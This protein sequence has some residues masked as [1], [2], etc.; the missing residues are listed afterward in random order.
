LSSRALPLS[1]SSTVVLLAAPAALLVGVLLAARTSTGL[2]AVV[3]LLYAPL[4]FFNLPLALTL[5]VPLT[6]MTSLHFAWSGPA[7]ISVM[8]LAAWIGTLAATRAQR[9]A[10]LSRQRFIVAAIVLFLLWGTLSVLW[11]TDSTRA[12]EA[13]LDWLVA[14][15]V[16]MIVATTITSPRQARF[17][18][19]AFVIGGVAS[20]IIGFATTGLRPSPS[21]LAGASQAEGRLTGGSGDPNYLAAG[22]VASIVIAAALLVTTRRAAARVGLLFAIAILVAGMVASQSRG[23][24]LASLGASLAALVLFKRRRLAVGGVLATIA[25]LAGLWLAADPSALHRLTNFNGGGTGRSDLWKIAWRVGTHHPIVGVGLD[26]FVTQESQYVREPGVLTSVALITDKPHV[27]HNLYLQAF[28][29]TGAIGFTLLIGMAV[30]FLSSGIRAARRFDIRGQ[31][32]LATLARAVVIAELSLFI[33]LF[34]LSDGPDERF[35][36]LFGAGAGLLGLARASHSEATGF[37]D[38]PRT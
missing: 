28:T 11:S 10:V 9:A 29:E 3:A 30:G 16:F 38:T 19:L 12:L 33:A 35:W 37:I 15:G 23:A 18:L 32:E 7:V 6:F 21:A 27:V 22:L 14:A 24:L 26:N 8:L 31:T 20:A 4:V 25:V 17:I 5:W 1:R 2:A 34:F 36:V 13:L